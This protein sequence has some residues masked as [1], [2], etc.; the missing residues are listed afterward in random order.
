MGEHA[1]QSHRLQGLRWV[2]VKLRAAYGKGIRWPDLPAAPSQWRTLE[3]RFQ[4]LRLGPE[5]QSGVEG[6]F[7]ISLGRSFSFQLTRFDQAASGLVQRVAVIDPSEG[8]DH[9]PCRAA[10]GCT[11]ENGRGDRRAGSVIQTVGDIA[12]RGWE[13][14]S[15]LRRGALTPK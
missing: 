7:D 15:S 9:D 6:G 2:S 13:L 3:E 10:G 8:A 5:V 11:P 1:L 14:Q 12:N 4:E